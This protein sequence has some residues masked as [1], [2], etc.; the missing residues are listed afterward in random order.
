MLL[1]LLQ[2]WLHDREGKSAGGNKLRNSY[3][4]R[5]LRDEGKVLITP[6]SRATEPVTPES[7]KPQ[8]GP[9][10]VSAMATSSGGTRCRWGCAKPTQGLPVSLD[11]ASH[12]RF[13]QTGQSK[14]TH[15]HL[16]P[17][18]VLRDPETS[19]WP[20]QAGP[21]EEGSESR[22]MP[23]PPTPSL[24]LARPRDVREA[25]SPADHS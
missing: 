13:S 5:S 3:R 23:L 19:Q 17:L 9:P 22:M 16:L 2:L 4:V 7:V 24:Q 18:A 6:A 8:L 25:C 14:G 12:T 21:P 11:L 1:T 10:L 15:G 20:G